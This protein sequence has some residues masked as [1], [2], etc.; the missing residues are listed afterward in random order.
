MCAK[1][2]IHFR[3][4]NILAWHVKNKILWNVYNMGDEGTFKKYIYRTI[5]NTLEIIEKATKI[6]K[7]AKISKNLQNHQIISSIISY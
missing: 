4:K 2:E 1:Q 5:S 3:A 7:I 6:L